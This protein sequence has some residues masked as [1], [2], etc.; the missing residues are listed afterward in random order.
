MHYTAQIPPSKEYQ[1]DRVDLGRIQLPVKLK[2]DRSS[3]PKTIPVRVKTTKNGQIEI[4]VFNEYSKE[5][6]YIIE[7]YYSEEILSKFQMSELFVSNPDANI[8]ILIKPLPENIEYFP[9]QLLSYFTVSIIP[10][11]KM[12]S[13]HIQFQVFDLNKNEILKEYN[14][15]LHHTVY[16]GISNFFLSPFLPLFSDYIDHS[17]N[18]R[19]FSVMR[20][21]F[22]AFSRDF[23]IDLNRDSQFRERFFISDSPRYSLVID[24]NKIDN[25]NETS[26]NKK[27]ESQFITALESALLSK[28]FSIFE[29]D[30]EKIT[31]IEI[32]RTI[33]IQ[34]FNYKEVGSRN[35]GYKS[36]KYMAICEDVKTGKIYWN[37]TVEYKIRNR[38][39]KDGSNVQVNFHTPGVKNIQ[40]EYDIIQ[41]SVSKLFHQLIRDGII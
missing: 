11:E 35:S 6:E 10:Y 24:S 20:R 8:L 2:L 41:Q 14:Y 39:P 25:S 13:G 16:E 21:A 30:E 4:S 9:D 38:I 17:T 26:L 22:Q 28:G 23:R 27:Y 15:D 36:I 34:N 5:N 31:A 37:Q 18:E 32:D 29:T 40:A 1:Q 12:S 19:S 33:K 7:N 3:I